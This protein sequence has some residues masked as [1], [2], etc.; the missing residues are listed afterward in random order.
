[1][2]SRLAN[3]ETAQVFHRTT[4]VLKDKK[5]MFLYE[6]D[7]LAKEI[8][9]YLKKSSAVLEVRPL[10]SL[11]RKK[12]TIGDID[13]V[14]KTQN[15][16]EVFRHF[17][18][19][20]KIKKFLTKNQG[21]S[22]KVLLTNQKQVNLRVVVPKDMG[23]VVQ[24]LTGSKA[25]NL[26]LKKFLSKRN[27]SLSSGSLK[28]LGSQEE[29][30]FEKEK[31]F[32]RFLGLDWI[33][34]ELREG[35]KEIEVAQNKKLPQLVK[36]S[37][38]KGDLHVHSNFPIG[39]SHDSGSASVQE[40]LNLAFEKGYQYLAFTEHNPS[41]SGHNK[42]EV[43]NIIK[44]KRKWV[45]QI[46]YSNK[47]G[48]NVRVKKLPFIFNSL[49]IDIKPAGDLALPKEA[50]EYLDFAVGGIHS[51]F[52][53][54]KEAMTKRI[55]KGLSHPKVKVWAHP[56]SRMLPYR[57][58][59]EID[60]EV[61]FAFCRK[62]NKILEIN[63]SPKRLDLPDTLIKQ[64]ISKKIKLVVNSDGH[65]LDQLALMP[66]GVFQARRGWAQK[67]DLVNT[68]DL[69]KVRVILLS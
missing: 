59:I 15:P 24:H 2:V 51:Q 36:V 9:K 60:W 4:A 31:T 42:K 26:L 40:I 16:K 8:A 25:H 17:A 47:E 37:D 50:F 38:I 63:A 30:S 54:S 39:S 64:A 5:R 53:L 6:A 11:R 28:N 27:L 12:E 58:P 57:P 61:V 19:F 41:Q 21:D 29:F 65:H 14:V 66:Y 68:L 55:L 1:M 44:K 52:S 7:I 33:P 35:H 69:D 34:P 67:T 20:P 10:G 56:T 18:S 22:F 23:L 32:Y 45:D 13:I 43:V 49:E 3:Q 62:N 48:L 46:N